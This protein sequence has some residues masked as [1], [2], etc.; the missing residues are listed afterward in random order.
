MRVRFVVAQG[1]VAAVSLGMSIATAWAQS[2]KLPDPADPDATAPAV[3]YE[4]AFSGYRSYQEQKPAPWK[5]VHEE[6]AGV[7][8][9]GGH[10]GH[11]MGAMGSVKEMPG[12]TMPSTDSGAGDAPKEGPM[13]HNMGSMKDMPGKAM[14][15]MAKPQ[16]APGQ[17]ATAQ[18]AVITGTGVV[19]SIDKANGKIKLTHD[20][21]AAL[22]WPKMTMFFRLKDGALADQIQEGEKVGFYLEK[23]A[24]GYVI[25]GFQK[26]MPES[27]RGRKE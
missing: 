5:Q 24:A 4:S 15:G 20:P 25:S 22:G 14:P 7:P 13:D 21:I 9:A 2:S 8:G 1:C 23:S 17:P 3:K 10:G 19:Q 18:T 16:T 11:N 6:V 12:M 26:A 27:D